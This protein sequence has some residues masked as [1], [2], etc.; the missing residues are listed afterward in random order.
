MNKV[1][2]MKALQSLD[3]QGIYVLSKNDLA[4]LFAQEEGKTLEKSLQRLVADGLLERVCK[5]VYLNPLARSK[6]VYVIEEIARV[7]RRGWLSYLSMESMLSEYGLISQLPMRGITVMTT[8]AKGMIDTTHGSI[9]F[10]H[11]RRR[12]PDILQNSIAIKNRPLRIATEATALRD[13]RRVGRNL[14]M[15]E[16]V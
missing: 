16:Q 9:E 2:A 3:R 10:T 5:G 6:G 15:L 14:G 13:L 4:K 8:G 12:V 11:T 7:L 1:T